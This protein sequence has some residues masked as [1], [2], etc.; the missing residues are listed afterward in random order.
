VTIIEQT[1]DVTLDD[2]LFALPPA[3]ETH[4]GG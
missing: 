4:A 3:A 1:R 2:G